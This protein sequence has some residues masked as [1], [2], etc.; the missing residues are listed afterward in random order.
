M[1]KLI[2]LGLLF[3]FVFNSTFAQA[4]ESI[5]DLRIKDLPNIKK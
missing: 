1:N 2:V 3:L 4:Q 5:E